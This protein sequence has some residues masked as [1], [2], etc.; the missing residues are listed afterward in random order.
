MLHSILHPFH[1]PMQMTGT[2]VT[3]DLPVLSGDK[4]AGC[5]PKKTPIPVL[6]LNHDNAFDTGDVV[7]LQ[8]STP[9][10]YTAAG[11][12]PLMDQHGG[13]AK[14]SLTAQ[15]LSAAGFKTYVVT[16]NDPV[17]ISDPVGA[18]TSIWNSM[19]GHPN[20]V[21]LQ[22]KDGLIRNL[23]WTQPPDGNVILYADVNR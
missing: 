13:E 22:E 3:T 12:R 2:V 6:D 8:A 5:V 14:G 18:F 21:H 16:P 10:K 11:L 7:L 20:G 9:G 15:D 17:S 4:L 19:A 1:K 23:Q